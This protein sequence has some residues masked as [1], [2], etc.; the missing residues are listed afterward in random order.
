[1]VVVLVAC[2]TSQSGSSATFFGPPK[3]VSGFI[4]CQRNL[5]ACFVGTIFVWDPSSEN[6]AVLD[7]W[8]ARLTQMSQSLFNLCLPLGPCPT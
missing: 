2:W 3:V 7:S 4:R 5:C 8:T 1:M 6:A